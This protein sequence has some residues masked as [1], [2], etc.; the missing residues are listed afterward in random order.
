MEM[1]LPRAR[2]RAKRHRIIGTGTRERTSRIIVRVAIRF[3]TSRFKHLRVH[4]RLTSRGC[5]KRATTTILRAPK[6][7][8]RALTR[9]SFTYSKLSRTQMVHIDR[10]TRRRAL[11][12]TTRP[13]NH[14]WQIIPIDQTHIVEIHSSGAESELR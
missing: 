11:T 10:T 1:N 9:V 5:I 2:R 14:H 6:R 7:L 4:R 3:W 8:A 12:R 13:V